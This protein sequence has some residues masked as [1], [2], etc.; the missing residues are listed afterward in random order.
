MLDRGWSVMFGKRSFLQ[1]KISVQEC[2]VS[3]VSVGKRVARL[4][5]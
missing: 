1:F 3:L 5:V 2:D 4:C